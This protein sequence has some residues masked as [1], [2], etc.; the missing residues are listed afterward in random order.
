M[1]DKCR[2][3]PQGADM[4]RTERISIRL[5]PATNAALERCAKQEMRT[6]SAMAEILLMEALRARGLL[7]PPEKDD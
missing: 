6:V 1:V 4:S 5:Q 3:Q 7:S 2:E